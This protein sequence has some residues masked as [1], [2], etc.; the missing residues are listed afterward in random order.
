MTRMR[1]ELEKIMMRMI[2]EDEEKDDVTKIMLTFSGQ[3]TRERELP[4]D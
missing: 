4:K 1:E 3:N 2:R